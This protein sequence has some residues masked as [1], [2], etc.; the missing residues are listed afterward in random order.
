MALALASDVLT[1]NAGIEVEHAFRRWLVGSLKFNYGFDDYVGS[2]RKDDR[3]SIGAA[4]T[5][6][7]NRIAQIKAEVREDW[8]RS[9]VPGVDYTATVYMLGVR[10]MR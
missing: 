5:Y 4:V 3:F 9:S 7:I 6:K 2:D 1:R 10:L 8:L